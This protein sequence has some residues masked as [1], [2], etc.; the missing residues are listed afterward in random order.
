MQDSSTVSYSPSSSFYASSEFA[1]AAVKV[2][3]GKSSPLHEEETFDLLP[4]V[5]TCVQRDM[6]KNKDVDLAPDP[7]LELSRRKE[8]GALHWTSLINSPESVYEVSPLRSP[9]ARVVHS[10]VSR[11][12]RLTKFLTRSHSDGA[13]HLP[14]HRSGVSSSRILWGE[15]TATQA[16]LACRTCNGRTNRRLTSAERIKSYLSDLIGVFAGMR[17]L[18]H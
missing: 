17:R 13:F 6:S 2:S 8:D 11:R 12:C 14:T 3:R 4:N 1:A 15:A 18:R 10:K 7:T 9:A 16:R 5:Q